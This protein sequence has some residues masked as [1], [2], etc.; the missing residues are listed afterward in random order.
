[1]LFRYHT[2]NPLHLSKAKTAPNLLFRS[3]YTSTG[4]VTTIS[5]KGEP[6]SYDTEIMIGK[7]GESYVYIKLEVGSAFRSAIIRQLGPVESAVAGH[8]ATL[9]LQFHHDSRHFAHKLVPIP[10][11]EIPRNI[12][13]SEGNLSSATLRLSGCWHSITINGTFDE[14]FERMARETDPEVDSALELLED[15]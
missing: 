8:P 5:P 14:R 9:A 15:S 3:F 2:L 10:R 11:I 7:P 1:M 6:V 12:S 13:Q 4:K